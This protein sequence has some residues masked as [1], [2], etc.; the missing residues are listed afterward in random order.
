MQAK[1]RLIKIVEIEATEKEI[2]KLDI[3]E[4][5][6]NFYLIRISNKDKFLTGK[7]LIENNFFEI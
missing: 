7:F 4:L 5:R 6:S 2:I 3:S 1:G